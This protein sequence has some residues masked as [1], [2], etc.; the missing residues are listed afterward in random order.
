VKAGGAVLAALGP[1][2][3]STG[4]VP[5]LG[6]PILESRY[7]S[8]EGERFHQAGSVDESHPAVA[9]AGKFENVKFYQVV[10][11]KP[12]QA[13]VLA[14]LT[15]ETPL[16][17]EKKL[18]EGRA[19]V[20][21]STL[22][23]IANDLPLHASFIPFVEQSAQY[24]S[25]VDPA[26]PHYVVGSF[27][28]LRSSRDSGSRVEVIGPDGGRALSLSDTATANAF[29]LEREGFYEVRRANG[30]HQLVAVHADRRESDLDLIPAETLALW[31]RQADLPQNPGVV[32]E[33][34][35]KPQSFWW[36]LALALLAA[37]A[38]ESIFSSRYLQAQAEAPVVRKKAA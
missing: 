7:A 13:R 21:A 33:L 9:R 31:G 8:R 1:G 30:R 34:S 38:V 16:V 3:A 2:A 14:K 35:E 20:F 19:I 10:R 22:D 25:G 27:I 26:S 18:G 29:E 12:A 5:L 23:N 17:F 15:D 4:R 37:A 28:E 32:S 6:D 24:L 11:V 36:Y